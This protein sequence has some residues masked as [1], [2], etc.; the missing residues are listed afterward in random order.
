MNPSPGRLIVVGTPIGNLSDISPRACQA[1]ATA[2]LIAAEDT[3]HSG[4]LLQHLSLKKSFLSVQKF[5]EA[6]RE[7]EIIE[8]LRSGQTIAL[9]TDSGMPAISDPG[10]RIIRAVRRENL[11]VEIIPGPTAPIHA[12]IASGLPTLPFYFGGFLPPKSGGR[13]KELTLAAARNH[14]SIYLESP[15]RLSKTL[16]VLV[17]VFPA[18]SQVCV[19]RELTKKFEEVFVG[20]PSKVATHFGEKAKGEITLVLS[21]LCR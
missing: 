15:H 3:R 20:T 8:R 6:S 21:P 1:L 16:A 12:L 5:N 7:S 11:P 18:D 9:V 14:T 4:L 2:D 13:L 19:A 17:E 10:E